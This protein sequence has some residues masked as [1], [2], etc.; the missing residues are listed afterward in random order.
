MKKHYFLI[1]ALIALFTLS[2][3]AATFT[4]SNNANSPGQYT[5]L[6]EAID[7]AAPN[8]T[9][10]V[11]GS[12]SSYGDISV[13]KKLIIIGAGYHSPYGDNS[14]IGKLYFV[15]T[16]LKY[17]SASGSKVMGF[18]ASTIILNADFYGSDDVTRSIDNVVIERCKIYTYIYMGYESSKIET[19]NNDTIRNCV[20]EGGIGSVMEQNG[21][22]YVD[23]FNSVAIHNNIFNSAT[24]TL[25]YWRDYY[26]TVYS[27]HIDASTCHLKNNVFLTNG[28]NCFSYVFNMVI[29]NNI[30]YAAEPQGGSECVFTKNI[31]YMCLNNTLPGDGNLGSGNLV[32]QNPLFLNY[33]IFGGGFDYS[34]DFHLQASSPGKNAGTDGTD[35]GIYGGWLPFEVGAN[36]YI[37]QMVEITLPSGSS[38]PAG[39]TLN[40]HFKAKKQN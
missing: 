40:V 32:N 25:G 11:A 26:G 4:V 22:N 19:F 17:T 8:D 28:S 5:S 27:V 34:Q 24:I 29:E 31:T 14:I 6:Q 3:Q 20:I 23:I 13:G 39:G 1:T 16:N 38:V 7:A 15:N 2:I 21:Y 36:P 33:P 10:L 30:F 35:I 12:P 37:P 9:I 18:I